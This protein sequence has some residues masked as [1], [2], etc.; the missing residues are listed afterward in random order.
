M[1]GREAAWGMVHKLQV[2]LFCT[3]FVPLALLWF[4]LTSSVQPAALSYLLPN[5]S[6]GHAPQPYASEAL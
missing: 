1:G 3:A 5:S 6:L 2:S 4:Q